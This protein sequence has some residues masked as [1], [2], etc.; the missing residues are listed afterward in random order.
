MNGDCPCKRGEVL[1]ALKL[2]PA[3]PASEPRSSGLK[4]VFII[5]SGES[6]HSRVVKQY[7]EATGLLLCC[8]VTGR[9]VVPDDCSPSVLHKSIFGAHVAVQ[10]DSSTYS[11]LYQNRLHLGVYCKVA[12]QT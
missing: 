11:H 3:T 5:A 8:S 2:R 9:P 7:G 4:R 1:V 6:A 10:H 12:W